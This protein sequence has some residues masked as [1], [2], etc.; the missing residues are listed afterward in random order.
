MYAPGR[1]L[2]GDEAPPAAPARAASA[3]ISAAR[4]GGSTTTP[5]A[6]P[7]QQ[8][9]RLHRR[10]PQAT[11][12][13][14]PTGRAGGRARRG[15]RPR[16]RTGCSSSAT[17]AASRR[18]PSVTM[19]AAPRVWA[20]RAR[21]S[22]M[23]PADASRRASMTS[24]SPGRICSIARFWAFI[25][26]PYRGEQVLAQ[27]QVAQ[28]LGEPGH[29]SCPAWSCG[30]PSMVMSLQPALA[31]LSASVAMATGRSPARSAAVATGR[32]AGPACGSAG[33]RPERGVPGLVRH[34]RHR[35]E[36][37]QGV[38]GLRR[39]GCAAVPSSP[40]RGGDLDL[41]QV[42][43][44]DDAS[45][46]PACPVRITSPGSRVI[47]RDRSATMSARPKSSVLAELGVLRELAVDPGAQLQR[48][49]VDRARRRAAAGRAA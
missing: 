39:S 37:R 28:G 46:R 47:S 35:A 6:S 42:A 27:R 21:M 33:R 5:S 38:L 48:G 29:R 30:R 31:Q 49:R 8:V 1:D 14:V 9:A 17:A 43:G 7:D 13:P 45:S 26:P 22:P 24:T 20:R 41:D 10:P 32:P 2:L 40:A 44:L 12:T 16:G 15:G 23:V 11:V 19:P 25:P 3:M 36:R 34:P 4:L 18:P